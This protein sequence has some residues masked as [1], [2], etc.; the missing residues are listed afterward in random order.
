[1]RILVTGLPDWQDADSVWSTLRDMG[2]TEVVHNGS[3]VGVDAAA[4]AWCEANS[5]PQIVHSPDEARGPEA[6]RENHLALL[7]EE[8]ELVISFLLQDL[9][10]INNVTSLPLTDLAPSKGVPVQFRSYD[11]TVYPYVDP[12]DP[13]TGH[14]PEEEPW[15]VPPLLEDNIPPAE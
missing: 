3:P 9:N 13:S 14:I 12:L 11:P 5:I 2:A 15:Q 10:D 6:E 8:P 4:A 1:M 7:A